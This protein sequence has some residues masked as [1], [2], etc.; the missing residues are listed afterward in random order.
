MSGEHQRFAKNVAALLGG[1]L[2]AARPIGEAILY[3]K[4]KDGRELVAKGV[5][6]QS[7]ASWRPGQAWAELVALDALNEVDAPVPKL[8]AADLHHGW[9]VEEFVAGDTLAKLLA[10]PPPGA[11]RSLT[12]GLFRLEEAFAAQWDI[13]ERWAAPP[14]ESDRRLAELVTPLL[15]AKARQAWT[16]LAAEATSAS[17]FRPG[18]L[19][20]RSANVVLARDVT[21]L[22][23]AS[24]GYDVTEKR[25]AAYAQIAGGAPASLLDQESYRFYQGF[26]SEEA[27]LRLAFYDFLFWGI[28]LLR[29]VAAAKAP[30]S[31]AAKAVREQWGKPGRLLPRYLAMWERER[32]AE[33]RI[34]RLRQGLVSLKEAH[35][36][37]GITSTGE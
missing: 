4:L 15:D 13:L 8:V 27:A 21:F 37:W 14:G 33:P 24:Y 7:L 3:L 16:E 5:A 34:E 23:M 32:I 20:V 31:R 25:L 11:F 22:D 1:E 9:L 30:T 18:P 19:D 28:G 12:R 10:H 29:L 36:R 17:V 35:A 26:Y 2:E 6:R